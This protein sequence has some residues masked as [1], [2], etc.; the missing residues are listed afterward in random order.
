MD[1]VRGNMK[2][3]MVAE[4]KLNKWTDSVLSKLQTFQGN[5]G[6]FGRKIIALNNSKSKLIRTF[7]NTNLRR[8]TNLQLTW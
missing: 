6:I 7:R 4:T 3:A 1:R 5:Y 8:A 2:V